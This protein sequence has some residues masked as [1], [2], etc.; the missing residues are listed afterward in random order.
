M[1]KLVIG[2]LA[3]TG[4]VLSAS[5]SFAQVIVGVSWNNFQEERWGKW[6]EP[7]IKARA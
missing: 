7:A 5:M 2:A 6:D 1:R 4:L 3:A